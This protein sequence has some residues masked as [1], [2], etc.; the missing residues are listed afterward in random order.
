[1][2]QPYNNE[3]HLADPDVHMSDERR[4][5]LPHQSNQDTREVSTVK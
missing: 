5:P 2:R 1:M 3:A 4:A